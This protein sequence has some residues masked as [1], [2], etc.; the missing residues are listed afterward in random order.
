MKTCCLINHFNYGS[1]VGEAIASA[2]GQ[3]RPFDE[4]IVVDDGS[5]EADLATLRSAAKEHAGQGVRVI[6]KE[7]GGQLSCFQ[8]GLD[9]TEADVIFFLD[10]DD[11]WE[12]EY[13][14]RV[15]DVFQEHPVV[16]MVMTNERRVHPDG[17]SDVTERPSRDVGYAVIRGLDRG[18]EWHGQP[19]SCIAVKRS[20]LM[21]IFPLPMARGWRTC[22][23]E[24]VIY[25]SAIVGARRWFLGEPLVRYRIHGANHFH[26]KAYDPADRLTRGIEVLRL[27]ECLRQRE[28]LPV[29]LAHMAHHEFRTIESP[30][31]SEYREYW[32]LVKGSNLPSHRKR[33]ILSALWGWYRLGKK[34]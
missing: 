17:S 10:A 13:A 27:V 33:R 31:K 23:D 29:C 34:I 9:A 12:P 3:S 15:L 7:N 30:T 2:A 25:G 24:A 20:I 11:T 18:G 22:A 8:A 1:Y 4:I 21:R 28:S 5:R 14:A 26:G 32:R 16:D 6:E 19:T